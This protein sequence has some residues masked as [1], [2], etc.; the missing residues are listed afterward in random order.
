MKILKIKGVK[1]KYLRQAAMYRRFSE[2]SMCFSKEMLLECYHNE[3]KGAPTSKN[4]GYTYG[5]WNKDICVA[6]WIEDIKKGD[7]CK[8]EFYTPK[9]KWW[10]V[11]ALKNVIIDVPFF[12]Y[13][14]R[15]LD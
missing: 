1:R 11:D 3:S 5:K 6:M 15:T 12:P 13:E 9:N 14:T 2:P 8:V 10:V 4:N 7:V